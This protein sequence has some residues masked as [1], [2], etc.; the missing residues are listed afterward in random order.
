MRS[1]GFIV[2]LCAC[3]TAAFAQEGLPAYRSVTLR[4]GLR[5]LLAP[6]S[7]AVAVDV[8]VWYPAGSRYEKS[9]QTGLTH[10]FERLMFRGSKSY[11]D[12]EHLRR[13]QAAGGL[14]NTATTADGSTFFETVPENAL[15]L[16]FQLEADRMSALKVTPGAFEAERRYVREERRAGMDRNPFAHGLRLLYATAF[17]DHPYGRPLLGFAADLDRLTLK[18]C[19]AWDAERYGAAGAL[20]TVVGR[21]D[22]DR[23]LELARRTFES[24]PRQGAGAAAPLRLAPQIAERRASERGE[25][26]V[27]VMLVGWRGPGDA[28]PDAPALELLAR[29]LGSGAESRL[30]RSLVGDGALVLAAQAG[31]ETRRDA[32]LFYAAAATRQ[33]ADSVTVEHILLEHLGRAAA[34]EVTGE[35]L[36]RARRQAELATLAGLQTVRGRAQALGTAQWL[37]GDPAGVQRRLDALRRATPADLRRAAQRVITESG[38]N[39][40]WVY[41][42]AATTSALPEGR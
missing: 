36:D 40:V 17:P 8:A 29:V 41:S 38:R 37:D 10:L 7:Q 23:T 34:E 35:E 19:V 28:D 26:A 39:L 9:G 25:G 11:P 12:G 13:I 22:P 24:L 27:S 33:G 16:A 5:V 21:F 15:E 30:P 2:L 18:D 14:A 6:D 42:T 32:S 1:L 4:N 20:L 31:F 3:S